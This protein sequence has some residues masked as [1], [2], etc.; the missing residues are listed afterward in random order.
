LIASIK[1]LTDATFVFTRKHSPEGKKLL[2][3]HE[4]E[5][6]TYLESLSH[7]TGELRKEGD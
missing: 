3:K 6:M 5:N 7:L 2:L 4:L 1:S